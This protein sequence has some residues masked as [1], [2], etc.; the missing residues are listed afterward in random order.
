MGFKQIDV[1]INSPILKSNESPLSDSFLIRNQ[2]LLGHSPFLNDAITGIG[3]YK[4]ELTPDLA[5]NEAMPGLSL[6]DQFF[7]L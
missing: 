6:F 5:A 2:E 3:L 7:F 1:F 4:G